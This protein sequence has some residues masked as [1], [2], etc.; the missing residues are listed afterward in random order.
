MKE[1]I[2]WNKPW[3][4]IDQQDWP[5]IFGTIFI[6][7]EFEFPAAYQFN[8]SVCEWVDDPDENLLVLGKF[9]S[10]KDARLFAQAKVDSK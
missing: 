8:Y 7:P 5:F 4:T 2:E 3:H 1:F 6:V 9:G 10:V